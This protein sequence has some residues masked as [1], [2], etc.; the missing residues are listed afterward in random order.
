MPFS[1]QALVTIFDPVDRDSLRFA[2]APQEFTSDASTEDASIALHNFGTLSRPTGRAPTRYRFRVTFY[3]GSRFAGGAGFIMQPSW[4]PPQDIKFQLE[5]WHDIQPR[6]PALQPLELSIYAEGFPRLWKPVYIASLSL[7]W[8]GAFGDLEADIG[9]TEW[10]AAIVGLDEPLDAVDA[11]GVAELEDEPPI[12]L[13]VLVHPGDSLWALAKRHLGD[14]ARYLELY[15]LNRDTIGANPNL[16]HPGQELLLPG[17][18]D[19]LD[20]PIDEPQDLAFSEWV[21]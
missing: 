6:R 8:R 7:T 1:Q 11:E 10:R 14:G 15:D 9:L 18:T 13:S 12:P 5:R 3:G 16:I 19:T 20:E 2:T 21:Q 4:R 17:G